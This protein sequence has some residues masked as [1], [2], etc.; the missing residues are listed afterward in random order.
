MDKENIYEYVL[1]QK[2]LIE[3]EC[4]KINTQLQTN[5]SFPDN[6]AQLIE[7]ANQTY[8][9]KKDIL[10]KLQ[11]E[12]AEKK[13]EAE[14]KNASKKTQANKLFLSYDDIIN[15][16]CSFPDGIYGVINYLP[17]T[18]TSN[19]KKANELIIKFITDKKFDY[20]NK[21]AIVKKLINKNKFTESA[22]EDFYGFVFLYEKN[23]DDISELNKVYLLKNGDINFIN[24]SNESDKE[25]ENKL[26]IDDNNKLAN[27]DNNKLANDDKS[28]DESDDDVKT[29]ESDNDKIITKIYNF[30]SEKKIVLKE[31]IYESN[32]VLM[33][34]EIDETS[35]D[36]KGKEKEKLEE[37][38]NLLSEKKKEYESFGKIVKKYKKYINDN[39]KSE[40]IRETFNNWTNIK[41]LIKK[42]S[43]PTK[44]I[45][46]I[47][48][49]TKFDWT[50]KFND[51]KISNRYDEL[52][53]S[54]LI[55]K[56]FDDNIEHIVL[57]LMD[58]YD[59]N[60]L[61][62]SYMY[63]FIEILLRAFI[64]EHL[65][66]QSYCFSKELCV[67]LK[68]DSIMTEP[69]TKKQALKKQY[70]KNALESSDNKR[71]VTSLLNI[72]NKKTQT[73]DQTLKYLSSLE[74]TALGQYHQQQQRL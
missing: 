10:E 21:P 63:A 30:V 11:E 9:N 48:V 42:I 28:D 59:L 35:Y 66:N 26:A 25:E 13:K 3:M 16:I 33:G 2:Q 70:W 27:D 64:D 46:D 55:K 71:I 6:I 38:I 67:Y 4:L 5:D 24:Q 73:I 1:G 18:N 45:L 32:F 19:E 39:I 40:D 37:E 12:F 34:E 8:K 36:D 69:D 29:E 72:L 22:N 44:C 15:M 56:Y 47:N 23:E 57:N 50:N 60:G 74:I 68:L 49:F 14:K 52:E 43:D 31:I 54:N 7:Q 65:S 62:K 17:L 51:V 61:F 58:I 53:Y 41:T 20:H